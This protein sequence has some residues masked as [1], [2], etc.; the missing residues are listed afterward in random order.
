MKEAFAFLAPVD[1][2]A[3]GLPHYPSIVSHPMDLT[4]AEYKLNASGPKAKG[5]SDKGKYENR[6]EAI[7]DIRRVWNNS[8]KFNGAD[9]LVSLSGRE[10]EKVF[11]KNLHLM[12]K[13][14]EV[15]PSLLLCYAIALPL[16]RRR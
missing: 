4:T 10:L 13:D 8:I 5:R 16:S 9:H 11:E 12:P 6:E 14:D 3:M 2:M 1:Y 7:T 15:S